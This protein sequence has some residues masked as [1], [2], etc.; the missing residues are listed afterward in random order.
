MVRIFLPACVVLLLTIVVAAAYANSLVRKR[1]EWILPAKPLQ[2]NKD[3]TRLEYI[4]KI[5]SDYEEHININYALEGIGASEAPFNV[6]IVDPRTGFIRVTR[7]L[8]REKIDTYNLSGI[9]TYMDG[10]HAE[11]KI[12]IRIKVIDENDNAPIF[13]KVIPP[14]EVFERSPAGTAVM[15]VTAIDLDEPGNPNSQI[16][17]TLERQ[18]PP[19]DLFYIKP[20]G[21]VY[22]K[23]DSLDRETVDRYVLRVRAAD[24]NGDPKGNSAIT[25]VVINILD[26]NDN[27]PT[28]EKTKLEA[29]IK[30]NTFGEE[31]MRFK[32]QDRDLENSDNWEPVYV[33]ARGNEAGYFSIKT[34]PVTKEG[35]LMLDKAVDYED[36]KKLNLGL[37][38]KNKVPLV[39][40]VDGFTNIG[41]SGG[42]SSSGTVET[43]GAASATGASGATG[44]S[45]VSGYSGYDMYSVKINVENEPEGP[46]FDPKVKAIPISEEGGTIKVNDII[47]RYPAIDQDTKELAKNV[48]YMKSKDPGNWLIIDP[49]TSEIKLNKL[50][51]RES[52]LLVNGTYYAEVLCISEDIPSKTATGTI[53]IQ[54]KDFNDHC[55]TLTLQEQTL[56]LTKNGALVNAVL[57]NAE[58]KDAFPNGP[59]FTFTIVPENTQGKWQ[60]QHLNDT[61][62]ILRTE[63]ESLWPGVY[64]V[65]LII[66]D[67]QGESC[68]EP[69]RVQVTV[70]TCENG[71]QCGRLGGNGKPEKKMEF[72]PAG[73][74]LLF[75]GLLLLL[76]LLLVA[77]LC[78]CGGAWGMPLEFAN[79]PYDTKSRLMSYHTEGQGEDKDVPELIMPTT[80]MDGNMHDMSHISSMEFQQN[81]MGF[82]QN[83]MSNM[84][85]QQISGMLEEGVNGYYQGQMDGGMGYGAG[86][87]DGTWRGMSQMGGSGFQSEYMSR[88][89]DTGIYDGMALPHHFLGQYYNQKV[90]SSEAQT[91]KDQLLEYK[92]EGQGSIAGSVGCCSSLAL[93][94]DLGFLEDLD[95]KFKTLAEICGGRTKVEVR[96]P[97]PPSTS[98][99]SHTTVSKVMAPGPLPEL[100]PTPL[101]PPKADVISSSDVRQSSERTQTL[102]VTEMNREAP[103]GLAPQGQVLFLQQQPQLYYTTAPVVQPMH[104]M[105]QPPVQNTVMLREAPG[106]NMQNVMLVN[107][108]QSGSTQG[109]V[110][111][112]QVVGQ[113]QG[114]V[115]VEKSHG[116]PTMSGSQ[117]MVLVEGKGPSGSKQVLNSGQGLAHPGVSGSQTV[118]LAQGPQPGSLSGALS[119]SQRVLVMG[120]NTTLDQNSGVKTRGQTESP[121]AHNK[122]S[123]SSTQNLTGNS[124]TPSSSRRVLVQESREVVLTN[125]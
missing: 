5:R 71:V 120:S 69:Q 25:T 18:E 17:Y 16:A 2:E 57:V 118:L 111:Q 13:P 62:R 78:Y 41:V 8:D 93:D 112:G 48:K 113:P 20:N 19:G 37:I 91:G 26:V 68:P 59:P 22:V 79:M 54:V 104:Y 114:M 73:I 116:G 108:Q 81:Q 39:D 84:G 27:A 96:G 49:N 92:Y 122:S 10:S 29:N 3:Y 11:T 94:N 21:T 70:C 52:P 75:L 60:V 98:I 66:T 64:E 15:N 105:V 35:I 72:G 115:L 47:G 100:I 45:A 12:D 56:C 67:Q 9:A 90:Q 101:P 103:R 85:F 65:E 34:D 97:P 95:P 82:Q 55:P 110:M 89:R 33:I 38:I 14:G 107:A 44:A 46:Q 74:G 88:E 24:L 61:G 117:T 63:E 99:S 86:Q 77:L 28:L 119:G 51:D 43:D 53:A 80:Q 23:R 32:A 123:S 109:L 30:E 76:L 58:D 87:M 125:L 102:S 7:I 36:V 50:P 4:A 83:Q 121:R 106:P 124:S 6:F 1:R 42:S 40:G 31:V